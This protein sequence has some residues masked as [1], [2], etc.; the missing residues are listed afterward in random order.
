M[1]TCF[2]RPKFLSL[3][4]LYL[5]LNIVFLFADTASDSRFPRGTQQTREEWHSKLQAALEAGLAAG[6]GIGLSAAII[7]EDNSIW[8]GTAGYSDPAHEMKIEKDMLFS[9]ASINKTFVAAAILLLVQ[10]GKL[11][12]EDPLGKWI[13]PHPYIDPKIKLYQLL[14]HTSGIYDFVKNDEGPIQRAWTDEDLKHHFT[15][16]EILCWV[17]EPY[18]AAGEGWHYSSTNYILLARIAEKIAG[19]PIQDVIRDDFLDRFSLNSTFT[20]VLKEMPKSKTM[21]ANWY[22]YDRDGKANNMSELPRT[23]L[24]SIA[25]ISM[26]TSA[27][28]L[29]KWMKVFLEGKFLKPELLQKA[30]TFHAP[31]PGEDWVE[32]YGLGIARSHIGDVE[33]QGHLGSGFGYKSAAVYLPKY[34]MSI[35]LLAN[36]NGPAIEIA[37]AQL[38]QAITAQF[39]GH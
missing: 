37:G 10:E 3:A 39:G 18:F 36:E 6:Q 17:K 19:K 34:K 35:A 33:W 21:A 26:F 30:L 20:S 13:D 4:T 31:T 28:D 38:I 7:F 32:G 24:S 5:F 1:N 12:L 25:Y 23:G 9:M 14:N 22:D 27:A 16:E 2:R 11:S 8:T 29:A 15:P